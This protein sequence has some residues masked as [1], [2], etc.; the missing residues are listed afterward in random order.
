M[1][2]AD[3]AFFHRIRVRYSEID[4]QAV[5]FNARYLDYADLGIVEYFRWL[6]IPVVPGPDTP[7][8][9]AAHAE[10]DYEKPIRLDEEIDIGVRTEKIGRTSLTLVLEM[11][12][13]DADD[14][15]ARAQLVYVHVDLRSGA[16]APLPAE[17]IARIGEKK[18]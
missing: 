11:H 7:E 9:H 13:H 4:G 16:P 14:L 8:F 6:G 3:F 15:R 1:P 12:G 10:V 17:V 5:V 18:A 2:R